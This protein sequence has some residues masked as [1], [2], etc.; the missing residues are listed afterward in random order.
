M[1]TETYRPSPQ[2]PVPSGSEDC[3]FVNVVA[4]VNKAKLPV[5]VF[6]HGG[7]YGQANG[8]FDMSPLIHTNK[9][10][11]IGVTIQYRL[12]AFGFLSSDEVASSGILNAGIHDMRFALQWV[13]E[14]IRLFGGDPEQVTIAGSSAGAGG[15]M[16]LGLANG[17]ADGT[18]L[19]KG[20]IASSPYLPT[21]WDYN[22]TRPTEYYRR[23]ADRAGCLPDQPT[24]NQSVFECLV[25]ADTETLQSAS[26]YVST[27]GQHGQWAFTPVTDGTLIRTRPSAQLLGGGG[28][29][30][31]ARL[32]SSNC[33]N[34][35]PYF[36]PQDIT[37]AGAFRAFVRATYPQ[38]SAADLARL[39]ALYAVPADAPRALANSDGEHAPFSTTR[40]AF[41]AGWQQAANNLYAEATFVCPS[42]WLADAYAGRGRGRAWRYQF[43][44]APGDHG[45]DLEPLLGLRAA[46]GGPAAAATTD[47]AFRG[48]L[49]AAW[50]N[51]AAGRAPGLSRAQARAL[52][53]ARG[54]VAAAG[55]R[56]W[57]AWTAGTPAMLNLNMTGGVLVAVDTMINGSTIPVPR[58]VAGNGTAA[59]AAEPLRARFR[60]ADG[61]AW[62][63]G[64][65]ARCDLWASLGAR[66]PA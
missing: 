28:R 2:R 20:L 66:V 48:A 31:G 6:I 43:S 11:F 47:A 14:Y 41:A 55:A 3:L 33:V 51:F 50:G 35:G 52:G 1:K 49:R 64:R 9:N 34:E 16:L 57:R 62:E 19:F 45:R 12:G 39:L 63:G 25:S 4:P 42:R 8:A 10:T 44:V 61:R 26:D 32:L 29:L 40:S 23:F 36:V 38:L 59:A 65:G 15:V 58:R 21:Q 56:A 53:P 7:G 17:G 37:T 18:S 27:T 22:G 46:D 5:M 30:N 24:A 54:D 60:L 13:Q